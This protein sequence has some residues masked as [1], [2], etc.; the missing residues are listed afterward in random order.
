MSNPGYVRSTDGNNADDGSTWALANAD[1]TGAIAD[2]VAG[3]TL[4]VSQSHAQTQATALTLTF[5]G[6]LASPNMVIFGNDAAEPPTALASIGSGSV[7]TTGGSSLTIAGAGL[8]W[9]RG[10]LV[11]GSGSTAATLTL[12]QTDACQQVFDETAFEI[13][14]TSSAARIAIGATSSTTENSCEL[15]SPTF[16]FAATTQGLNLAR[17][18]R[19]YGGSI[20]NAGSKPANLVATAPAGSL[21]CVIEG[22]DA[23][24]CATTFNWIAS[25]A[26]ASGLLRLIDCRVPASWSGGLVAGA[27][28]NP[29]FRVEALNMTNGAQSYGLWVEDYYGTILTEATVVLTG[30]ATDGVTP[31]SWKMASNGSAKYP[32]GC[33]ESPPIDLFF[34]TSDVGVSKTITVEIVTDGV[35]L[36]DD[37]IALD[38]VAQTTSGSPLATRSSTAK[39]NPLSAG[40]NVTTSTAT[41]TTTGLTSPTKQKLTLSVTPAYEG[42]AMAVVKLCKAST[43]V[44][45]DCQPT[46][47]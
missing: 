15:R 11:C 39:S 32:G 19:I 5:P 34:G 25:G 35:T 17:Q 42:P 22:F 29:S 26:A 7:S 23:S 2:A 12:A 1:L 14:T 47:T 40:S 6:T 16:K 43:T 37:E 36:K 45:V 27:I 31:V 44:F 9:K 18:V 28:N 24:N 21:D 13:G 4:H 20:D 33:L 46:V 8:Y 3:E 30:G 38:L 41:W 10:K